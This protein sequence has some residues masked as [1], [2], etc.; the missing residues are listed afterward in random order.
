MS[1]SIN[2]KLPTEILL[3]IFAIIIYSHP[4][5]FTSRA[6]HVT[7]S[8]V[9]QLWHVITNANKSLWT[10]LS[11]HSM[12]LRS[13]GLTDE[14]HLESY[15]E[16]AINAL[17]KVLHRSHPL[18]LTL[19]IHPSNPLCDDINRFLLQ[20]SERWRDVLLSSFRGINPSHE[21]FPMLQSMIICNRELCD[22]TYF[23]W[24]RFFGPRLQS[25]YLRFPAIHPCSVQRDVHISATNI[26]TLEIPP[27]LDILRHC[28]NLQFLKISY[29]RR[30]HYCGDIT[31]V[32]LEHLTHLHCHATSLPHIL[33]KIHLRTLHF[34]QV[35]GHCM[36]H[37]T[38]LSNFLRKCGHLLKTIVFRGTDLGGVTI[39]ELLSYAQGISEI[40]IVEHP[41]EFSFPTTQLI[42]SLSMVQSLTITNH[43]INWSAIAALA[44]AHSRLPLQLIVEDPTG[45]GAEVDIQGLLSPELAEQIHRLEDDGRLVIKY[46]ELR[47]DYWEKKFI[48]LVYSTS[49]FSPC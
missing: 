25:L 33:P 38:T 40:E 47:Q 27:C 9:C 39:T 41:P 1:P 20:H 5:N 4:F 24:W 31:L 32:T 17:D 10:A 13:D 16:R 26:T 14:R 23:N 3:K 37:S 49:R 2:E 21:G 46:G 35:D 6:P 11:V 42:P 45:W 29:Q 48:L 22:P 15:M 28:T 36:Q 44:G 18:P 30:R 8:L 12:A 19:E 43:A 34:L 7:L